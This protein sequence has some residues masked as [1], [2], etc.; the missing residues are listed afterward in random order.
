MTLLDAPKYDE[1]LARNRQLVLYCCVGLAFVLILVFWL[2]SGRPIDWPW[3]WYTH[4]AGRSTVNRFLTS[5]E[6][7]ELEKAY[8]IWHNDPDWQKHLA[9]MDAMPLVR[10]Q[11]EHSSIKGDKELYK[12]YGDFLHD[13]NWRSQ[14]SNL[15]SYPFDRFQRDWSSTSPDNEYGAIQSHKIVAARVYKNVLLLGVLI[16][17]RKSKALFL[18]YYP[19]DHTLNFAPPDEELYLGP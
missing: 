16:N 7:N 12:A 4:F 5:V 3:N 17:G 13:E 14:Q 1:E 15:L 10:F 18:T 11:Q 19:K 6:K 9:Q 8:G 2:V